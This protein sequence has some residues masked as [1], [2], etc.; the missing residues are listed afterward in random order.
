MKFYSFDHDL[1]P[2]TLLLKLDP[3]IVKMYMCTKPQQTQTDRQTDST[4][5]I[6][7]PHTLMVKKAARMALYVAAST[8]IVT[9]GITDNIIH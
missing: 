4:E 7:Y 9:M 6:T 8:L 2:M 3:D 1:T 5:V